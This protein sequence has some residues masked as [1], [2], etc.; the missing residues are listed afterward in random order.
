MNGITNL[1]SA[2]VV[3]WAVWRTGGGASPG[4]GP[5]GAADW[6]RGG[7]ACAGDAAGDG[8]GAGDGEAGAIENGGVA[9][10]AEGAGL[11]GATEVCGTVAGAGAAGNVNLG[12]IGVLPCSR[13][14][15]MS[16]GT[17]CA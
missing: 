13:S 16:K 10:V 11:V 4:A 17:V 6:G 14:P 15:D 12:T 9:G 5:T 1:W 8:A 3:L 7:S 2:A